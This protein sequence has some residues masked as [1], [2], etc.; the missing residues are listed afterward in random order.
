MSNIKSKSGLQSKNFEK[1]VDNK[2]TGL[3][4]LINKNGCEIAITNYGAR[5]ASLVVPD[6]NENLIDVVT[7][8][9]N[10]DDYIR[11]EE[12]YFGA[13]CG[14]TCNRIANGQFTLNNKKGVSHK[15]CK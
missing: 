10:I 13:I 5:V 2:R 15:L 8:H 3:F 7:G 4:M 14:R 12:P 1:T 9:S 6:K 11:S